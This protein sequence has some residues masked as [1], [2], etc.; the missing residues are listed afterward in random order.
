MI[1][2]IN[3]KENIIIRILKFFHIIKEYEIDKS[4]MCKAA[5]NICNHNCETC[6]WNR[7]M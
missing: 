1:N 6:A 3:K 5:Q 7:A 2:L 4:E